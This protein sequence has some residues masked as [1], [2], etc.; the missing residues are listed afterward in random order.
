VKTKDRRPS[1]WVEVSLGLQS[2][3]KNLWEHGRITSVPC[4]HNNS[5]RYPWQGNILW[6]NRCL[7]L[8]LLRIRTFFEWSPNNSI[9][10]TFPR[11]DRSHYQDR[12][13]NVRPSDHH[14]LQVSNIQGWAYAYIYHP[15]CLKDV[16]VPSFTNPYNLRAIS[17]SSRC[18]LVISLGCYLVISVW[19]EL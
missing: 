8:S 13:R 18:V 14:T 1:W 15:W 9:G 7:Q 16:C 6:C 5:E 12:W 2:A 11:K 10:C 17:L 19:T 3:W 4:S